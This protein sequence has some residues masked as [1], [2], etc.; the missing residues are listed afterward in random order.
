MTQSPDSKV[1]RKE[2]IQMRRMKREN[3]FLK[4]ENGRLKRS[5]EIVKKLSRKDFSKIMKMNKCYKMMNVEL[6]GYADNLKQD[7]SKHSRFVKSLIFKQMLT[8]SF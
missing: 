3:E 5:L 1:K 6:Q 4:S 7:I 2:T 8:E